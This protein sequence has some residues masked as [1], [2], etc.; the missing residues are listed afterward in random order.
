MTTAQAIANKSQSDFA[1][2][3]K[4]AREQGHKAAIW[5][6]GCEYR[7]DDGSALVLRNGRVE[8]PRPQIE[9]NETEF[10]D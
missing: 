5:A 2:A 6:H 10:A 7:F 4:A 8:S 1:A 9:I 3:I